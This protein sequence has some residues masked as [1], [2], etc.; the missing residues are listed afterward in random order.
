MTITF[1][2]NK[3]I[4]KEQLYNLFN[5]VA[6]ASAKYPEK[7]QLAIKC[8]HKVISAWHS[9]N[10][11]GLL[12]SLSDGVMTAYFHYMLV[13]P[14]YQ[15]QGIGKKLL[16]LM[17]QEYKDYP[18]K[19]LISYEQAKEFYIKCGFNTEEGTVPFFITELV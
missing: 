16:E 12:N 10:L 8:S 15:G 11:V 1:S 19:V 7:L 3:D 6:W 14:E 17:L 13:R 18:T 2:N 5:S 9:G 4:E